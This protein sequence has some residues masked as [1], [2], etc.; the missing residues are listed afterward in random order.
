MAKVYV[1]NNGK[2]WIARGEG[3]PS[4]LFSSNPKGKENVK[5]TF[6]FDY[7]SWCE[8]NQ[9]IDWIDGKPD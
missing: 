8:K 7:P 9:P 4:F 1:W 2:Q 5:K 3:M 6:Q